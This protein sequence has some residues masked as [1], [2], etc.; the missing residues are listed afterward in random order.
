MNEFEQLV[1]RM[2]E[3]Q[4]AYFNNNRSYS[5]LNKA[6]KLEAAVDR[7]LNGLNKPKPDATQKSIF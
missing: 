4:N 6:K 3:A 1:C 7:H 5:N 2:R